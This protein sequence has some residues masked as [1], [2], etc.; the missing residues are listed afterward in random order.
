[1]TKHKAIKQLP[2]KDRYKISK[3]DKDF[4]ILRNDNTI[5]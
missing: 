1:M 4:I 3:S 5:Y 2:I